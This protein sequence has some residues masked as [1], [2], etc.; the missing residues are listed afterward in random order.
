MA[1]R[2]RVTSVMAAESSRPEPTGQTRIERT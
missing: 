1:A 2:M